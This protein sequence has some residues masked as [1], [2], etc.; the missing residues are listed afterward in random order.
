M[1]VQQIIV[2]M[3]INYQEKK[4]IYLTNNYFY[5]NKCNYIVITVISLM[6]LLN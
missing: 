4:S 3:V 2:F 1:Y 6:L 5:N